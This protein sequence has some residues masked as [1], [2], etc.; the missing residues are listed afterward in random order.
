MSYLK[1]KHPNI[2]ARC[3]RV[4]HLDDR[5]GEIAEDLEAVAQ[6]HEQADSS[7]AAQVAGIADEL[8]DELKQRIEKCETRRST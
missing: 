7:T 5:I 3:A 2:Y 1:L 4:R 6:A 8:I